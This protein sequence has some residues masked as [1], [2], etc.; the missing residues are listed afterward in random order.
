R[1][2]DA[3]SDWRKL[4]VL[5]PHKGAL[6]EQLKSLSILRDLVGDEV[7]I[8]QTI[9][10]PLSQAKNLA[11]QDRMMQHLHEEPTD[12]EIGLETI[13]RS[14]IDFVEAVLNTGVDGIFYA[15]QH[16][17]YQFFDDQA[18]ARFGSPYDLEILEAA[19][20][21]WLNVLHL[22]GKA[23]MFDLATSY[24]VQ[25]VNWHDRE[26]E[27]TILRGREKVAV[28]VCGGVSR[29][30]LELGTPDLVRSEAEETLGTLEK[31]GVVLGTGCVTSTIAPRTNIEAL[32]S[33]VNFA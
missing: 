28:A 27:P 22:H 14:T 8:I 12:F 18:Y 32:R 17:S 29:S 5:D 15:I 20:A 19:E 3:S 7:P 2:I 13:T 25:V 33:A 1:V 9:F 6:G 24:P 31:R 23:I 10:S 16:A 4:A 11:G 30:T 21:G 26:V